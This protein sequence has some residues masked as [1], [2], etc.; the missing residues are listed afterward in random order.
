ML[1]ANEKENIETFFIIPTNTTD[2]VPEDIRMY[3][4]RI[5]STGDSANENRT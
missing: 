4:Y 1:F 2:P 5:L 3:I